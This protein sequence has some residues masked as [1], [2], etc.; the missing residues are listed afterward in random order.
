MLRAASISIL[1]FLF[2]LLLFLYGARVGTLVFFEAPV[3]SCRELY[4][5]RVRVGTCMLRFVLYVTV[6]E[7]GGPH[8]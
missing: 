8:S 4:R 1:F 7:N 2:I 6:R 5:T 3:R